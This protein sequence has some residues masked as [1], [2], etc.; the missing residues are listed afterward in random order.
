MDDSPMVDGLPVQRRPY[1]YGF[2]E[3]DDEV[4]EA[5]VGGLLNK[6]PSS[7]AEASRF[8]H[9]QHQIDL[10]VRK[11]PEE[12]RYRGYYPPA[13]VVGTTPPGEA[14]N[15]EDIL[16]KVNFNRAPNYAYSRHSDQAIVK[17]VYFTKE[18]FFSIQLDEKLG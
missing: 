12:T 13:G 8:A 7:S 9:Y 14:A 4:F 1:G 2:D 5:D 17:A 16:H 15:A 11:E 3:D 18:F 10:R 6:Y